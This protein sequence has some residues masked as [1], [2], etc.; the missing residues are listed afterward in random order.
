M[1]EAF[2]QRILNDYR[3]NQLFYGSNGVYFQ[4]WVLEL[5]IEQETDY[6][7]LYGRCMPFDYQSNKWN[8][9]FNKHNKSIRIEDLD[10][11][12]ISLSFSTSAD[13][14]KDFMTKLL[15]ENSFI[16]ASQKASIEFDEKLNG[17][18]NCLKIPE[19]YCIRPI[20]HLPPKENYVWDTNK[21]SPS[22]I[23]SYD[24]AAISPIS[25]NN[26]LQS[27]NVFDVQKILQKISEKLRQEKI[28]IGENNKPL[29]AWRFGD[30]EFFSSREISNTEEIKYQFNIRNELFLEIYERISDNPLIIILKLFNSQSLFKSF[31]KQVEPSQYPFKLDF[32]LNDFNKSI[33]RSYTLEVYEKL[34][35]EE[36]LIIQ[37]GGYLLREASVV[38]NAISSVSYSDED[39]WLS[40]SVPKSKLTRVNELNS[41]ARLTNHRSES[42]INN[43]DI[44]LWVNSNRNIENYLARLLPNKSS[45]RFF[46]KLS[47]NGESRLELAEWL[48]DILAKH[49]NANWA[50]FDPFMEDVGI[51]LINKFVFKS[52]NYL[53]FTSKSNEG[54]DRVKNL[55]QQC[56]LWVDAIGSINLKVVEID[57]LHD[58]MLLVRDKNGL[59]LE[60]YHLSNSIQRANENFPLLITE[61]PLDTLYSIFSYI[62]ELIQVQNAKNKPYLFDS[63]TYH[64][65]KNSENS[66]YD[67]P[68]MGAVLAKWWENSKLS[69]LS[70]SLLKTEMQNLGLDFE[71][72]GS[73]YETIPDK[74][75]E[76]AFSSENFLQ[77]WSAFGELL[78][79][80]LAGSYCY[81]VG[82]RAISENLAES[83]L[84][85]LNYTTNNTFKPRRKKSTVINL[86][87]YMGKTF[88]ELIQIERPHHIFNYEP[89]EIPHGDM[90]AI[91]VLW[92]SQ[93]ET[94]INWL[95]IQ[96]GGFDKDNN[97][98]RALIT[99]TLIYICGDDCSFEKRSLL[100]NCEH[101]LLKWI[102]VNKLASL[103][104]REEIDTNQL[105]SV[106]ELTKSIDTKRV[107]Y[108][109]L[110]RSSMLRY[111]NE[112]EFKQN[113]FDECFLSNVIESLNAESISNDDIKELLDRLRGRTGELYNLYCWILEYFL[114]PMVSKNIINYTQVI[115]IWV[116]ELE[117]KWDKYLKD[118]NGSLIFSLATDGKFVEEIVYLFEKVEDE[119]KLKI[120]KRLEKSSNTPIRNIRKPLSKTSNYKQFSTSYRI[121]VWIIS[122]FK[123]LEKINNTDLIQNEIRRNISEIS[124]ILKRTKLNSNDDLQKIF[125]ISSL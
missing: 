93:P 46:S 10:I 99:D 37:K 97:R 26:F 1:L 72:N 58:R 95:D 14:F 23:S 83:L 120:V 70:G 94:L 16:T 84:V 24:S 29:D 108:L 110:I 2:S 82:N 3:L 102:G 6:Q 96:L 7:W 31:I 115:D 40:K 125:D 60:G 104:F 36:N 91:K 87:H 34:G 17:L 77:E 57:K 69:A 30:L 35:S 123:S 47:E 5:K 50:W 8:S 81:E 98:Q 38:I 71:E 67:T 66:I 112:S 109:W 62:D 28:F 113:L 33:I 51:N 21:L 32:P 56:E 106:I 118:E 105:C 88:Q 45:S 41:V 54:Q 59:P 27:L 22:N 61:I 55:V 80:T 11:T 86:S 111:N 42:R 116:S 78:A 15:E 90:Y 52:G 9:D 53:I 13:S 92:L 119:Q 114:E 124:E 122:I 103:F 121:I 18:L 76:D 48:K 43:I 12:I 63:T 4:A 25:K 89:N 68:Y 79:N 39:P 49:P 44:D 100:F 117:I 101:K 19:P 73:K 85:Y 20:M 64:V 65:K 107:I 75:W 74:F